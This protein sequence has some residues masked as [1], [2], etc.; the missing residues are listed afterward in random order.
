PFDDI[1]YKKFDVLK[2]QL[3]SSSLI[4]GVTGAQDV[5]GSHL[6]QSGVEFKL[7]NDPKR[8]LTSTRLIVDPDYLDVYKI[9]LAMGRNFSNDKSANGREYIINEAL[10]KELLKDKRGAPESAL[11]GAHFG[12]DSLGTI[13][14]IAKNFNFNSL[15]Y[16]IETMFMFNQKDWGLSNMSVKINGAKASEAINFI[17]KTWNSACPGHPFDYQFLDD[18]FNEVYRA[19]TQ[20]S[21]IVGVL[22]GLAIFISCLGLFGLASYSA[23][24]RVKEIGV[25]KVLGASVQRI[26]LLLSGHFLKLVVIANIIA[27]PL[28]WWA[29]SKWLQ[30]FAY[31]I[32][33]TWATFGVVAFLSVF[34]ALATISFQSVKAATANPVKSLRSE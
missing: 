6:D 30:N 23:E 9:K 7:G 1:T 3:L 5:L 15:H 26:V 22:A 2:Q 8:N 25:R 32:D 12:F 21:T 10:A 11:L 17:K 27:W 16:K 13:V 20:V 28:A 19:D 29:V 4:Q 18:H 14:G 31:R 24:K 33:L 34:I